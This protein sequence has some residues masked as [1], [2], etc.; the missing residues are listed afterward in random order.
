VILGGGSDRFI[1]GPLREIVWGSDDVDQLPDTEVDVFDT[2]EGA[3]RVYTGSVNHAGSDVIR[4]G[5]GADL[6]LIEG[7]YAGV[8][9]DVGAGRNQV[10]MSRPSAG[11]DPWHV[12]AAARTIQQGAVSWHWQGPVVSF[13]LHDDV[14]DLSF[15]GSTAGESLVLNSDGPRA[16]IAMSEGDDVVVVL[17]P[18]AD[19]SSYSLG[20][21][22]DSLSVRG[23]KIDGTEWIESFLHVDLAAHLLFY[24][25]QAAT[26]AAT[27]RGVEALT[28]GAALVRVDGSEAAETIVASGCQVLIAGGA[29]PDLL[30]RHEGPL[31]NCPSIRSRLVG[32]PGADTLIGSNRLDDVLLGGAGRDVADGQHGDDR[33]V[34]EVVRHCER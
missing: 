29:G 30:E 19:G 9:L 22:D 32:G 26:P 15:A 2:G 28:A 31:G 3:D 27:V 17:T 13:S 33:C 12:D 5:P 20:G 8:R 24:E 25:P 18:P 4:T 14:S 21:G 11:S 34:A 6:V 16:R 10:M 7:Y 1:G 23:R